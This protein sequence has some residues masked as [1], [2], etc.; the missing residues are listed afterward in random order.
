MTE[1][2]GTKILLTGASSGIGRTL[3]LELARE[4][5]SLYITGR[6]LKRLR[7]AE[8][9]SSV[10]GTPVYSGL[11]DITKEDS[12]RRTAAAVRK[13]LGGL[14][15][16]I[17][18]AGGEFFWGPFSSQKPE[19]E[20]LQIQTN[21]LGTLGMIRAVLPGMLNQG[22]GIIVNM[23]SL[24][25]II[26]TAGMASY[27]ASKFALVGIS[28]AL[29]GE[30]KPRGVRVLCV[31]PPN[32]DTPMLG[33]TKLPGYPVPVSPEAVASAVIQGIKRK[34]PRIWVGVSWPMSLL[35]RLFPSYVE[36]VLARKLR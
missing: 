25:G 28:R 33:R 5:A 16:L 12:V 20:L 2:K 17:N 26:P 7:A 8:K 23:A 10:F 27:S 15:I 19:T 32:A 36:G 30:L 21:Y 34:S 29:D 6:N 4:G 9:E 13:A 14:D 11:L 22:R 24:T 3:A 18:N 35:Y 1:L 31:L